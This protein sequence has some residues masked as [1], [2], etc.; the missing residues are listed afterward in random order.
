LKH[1]ATLDGLELRE[2]YQVQVAGIG[3][4]PTRVWS[5]AVISG[6]VS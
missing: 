1:K 6:Y 2:Q 3:S 4:D 5:V